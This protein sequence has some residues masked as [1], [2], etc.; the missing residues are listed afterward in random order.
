M[1]FFSA[2]SRSEMF[3]AHRGSDAQKAKN[4]KRAKIF[5]FIV[6]FLIIGGILMKVESELKSE[7]L[8][9]LHKENQ[10][11]VVPNGERKETARRSCVHK[12]CTEHI[13]VVKQEHLLLCNETL[14]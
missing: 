3:S 8:P 11:D 14:F 7:N 10:R 6:L 13:F 4:I 5:V 9:K 2:A 1:P 12:N